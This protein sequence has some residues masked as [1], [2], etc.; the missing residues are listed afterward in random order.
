MMT[1]YTC[2]IASAAERCQLPAALV[3]ALV[4]VESGGNP[5]AWNPEPHYR[6]LWD[7]VKK[8]PFRTL[9]PEERA[10]ERPPADFPAVAGDRD[11]EWWGQQ[12]SWGLCQVMGAVARERGFTGPYLPQLCDPQT[13][14]IIG[15]RHL[16]AMLE[17]AD[18]DMEK[19]LGAYNAGIGGYNSAL[20]RQYAAKVF[21]RMKAK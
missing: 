15:C 11:Q 12:A 3:E 9:T 17:W 6:Y 13:N 1:G 2:E 21:G 4:M 8:R 14:L 5:W 18:G 10:S 16:R 20:G 7:V 19:A